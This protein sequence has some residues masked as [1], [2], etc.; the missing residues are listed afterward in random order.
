MG[1]GGPGEHIAGEGLVSVCDGASD[2]VKFQQA[3]RVS[4]HSCVGDLG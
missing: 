2:A 4:C 3:G 1:G